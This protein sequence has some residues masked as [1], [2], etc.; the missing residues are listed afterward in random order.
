MSKSW[1]IFA[2]L[3][4]VLVVAVSLLGA[5]TTD[6]EV[7]EPPE[8]GEPEAAAPE[9]QAKYIFFFIGDGFGIEQR[10][11]AEVYL[12]SI[13]YSI[14]DYEDL[15]KTQLTMTTLPAQGMTTTYS[16]DSAITDSA[17]SGTA[18]ATGYKTNSGVIAMDTSLTV[19]YETLAEMAHDAGMK[20][21]IIT[22]VSLDHAT[23]ACFYAHNPSRKDFYD[24]GMQLAQS[25]FEF[26]G[27]GAFSLPTGKEGDQPSVLDAAAANGFTIVDNNTDF[28]NLAPGV[29]KVIAMNET[30]IIEDSVCPAIP[31]EI[32]RPADGITLAEYTAKAIELL[33]NPDG[34]FIMV[35]GGKIDWACHY[36]DAATAILDTLAFDEAID[37]AVAF[38]AQHPDETLIVVGADHGCGGMTIGFA[39]TYYDSFF[40]KIQYQTMSSAMFSAE[41]AEYKAAHPEG[42]TLEDLY[43]LIE[44][45]YGLEV[46]TDSDMAL[47][48]Y[49]LALLEE[50]FPYSMMSFG[51]RMSDP[52]SV[53]L[54][55]AFEPLGVACTHVLNQKAGIGWTSFVHTGAPVG[56][57]A[58]G[59]G[60]ELF[61]GYFD[62]TDVPKK[63]MEIAGFD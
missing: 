47:A 49:E 6:E 28:Y 58:I 59:V 50:A 33:D 23:P 42:V 22:S 16:A 39:G 15:G 46:G 7:T 35:E 9:A 60:E 34:F 18:L 48:D 40:D 56:I 54:F 30:L 24:I 53:R 17:A 19:E 1:K 62:N 55:Y 26:F 27:G 61:N 57:S 8:T 5:C 10:S 20:V 21:G 37:E 36:N 38:Y 63:I 51:E 52:T 29:G 4:I 14:T 41:L 13:N 44:E 32:D 45:A 31:Y 2:S 43:P 3:L 25:D 11:A 12:Y